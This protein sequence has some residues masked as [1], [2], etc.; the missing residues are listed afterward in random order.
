[1]EPIGCFWVRHCHNN[2]DNNSK[3]KNKNKNN[4]NKNNNNSNNN[5]DDNNSSN[6]IH[7]IQV[8]QPI[9]RYLLPC[10][11]TI[12]MWQDGL[13]YGYRQQLSVHG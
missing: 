12:A 5:N 6:H 13:V 7:H 10:P 4:K 2:N 9:A 1:M 8:F 3:N 11:N